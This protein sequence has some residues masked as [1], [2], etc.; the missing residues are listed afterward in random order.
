LQGIGGSMMV[1]VGRLIVLRAIP[2]AGLVGALAW[3]TVP[4]RLGPVMGPPL[5]G[6]I[7]T[8]FHWRWIFWINIP[9]SVLGVWL[10]TRFIPRLPLAAIPQFDWR[11]FALVGPGLAAFLTGVT[12]A[13][14][15]ILSSAFVA[16]LTASG[17]ILVMAYV[18]HALRVREPLVDLRLM[19]LATFWFARLDAHSGAALLDRR[20]AGWA[21][22][23]VTDLSGTFRMAAVRAGHAAFD[24]LHAKLPT[25]RAGRPA[26]GIAH[27]HHL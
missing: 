20:A 3:L 14:L 22:R 7:T 4:A 27:R 23:T 18:W 19:R 26:R 11:G 9:I 1:P 15:G 21:Q 10:V 17:M 16:L 2:K 6:F 8:C 13:G 5:G 25:G 24:H 12:L